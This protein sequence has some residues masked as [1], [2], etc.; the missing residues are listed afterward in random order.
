VGLVVFNMIPAFPM[1]GGRVL[2]ALLAIPL[3]QVQ[4][5]RIAAAFGAVFAVLLGFAGVLSLVVP[6]LG[7]GNPLLIFVGA[8]VL[9]V[10]QQELAMALHRD[11]QRRTRPVQVMP[12]S[13]EDIPRVVPVEPEAP[14]FDLVWDEHERVWVVCRNGRPIHS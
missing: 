12:T 4:A 10:G 14:V 8:F 13:Y 6:G 1:D 5:T 2:R 7:F 9:L 11:A 3:G